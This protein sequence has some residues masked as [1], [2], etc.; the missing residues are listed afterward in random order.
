MGL[1][2]GVSYLYN[3]QGYTVGAEEGRL[4]SGGILASKY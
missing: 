3:I 2:T 1:Y 4:D